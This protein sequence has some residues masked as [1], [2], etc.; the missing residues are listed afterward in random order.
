MSMLFHTHMLNVTG[1]VLIINYVDTMYFWYE[2]KVRRPPFLIGN[3]LLISKQKKKGNLL[4]YERQ[5]L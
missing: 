3:L 2:I 4:L 1:A 5:K